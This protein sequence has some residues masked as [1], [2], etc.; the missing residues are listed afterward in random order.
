MAQIQ[1]FGVNWT[2]MDDC[3]DE[4]QFLIERP[5]NKIY[6][7]GVQ[8]PTHR[9]RPFAPSILIRKMDGSQQI[10]LP[11]LQGKGKK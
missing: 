4:T 9:K 11:F 10:P 8:R 6:I 3:S 2:T 1:D 7:S 5:Q